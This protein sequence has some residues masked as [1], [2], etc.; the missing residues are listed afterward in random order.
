[1]VLGASTRCPAGHVLD[2]FLLS[3]VAQWWCPP[4]APGRGMSQPDRSRPHEGRLQWPGGHHPRAT[5]GRQ[6]A[7]E[8]PT[9]R[10]HWPEGKLWLS[11]VIDRGEKQ[12]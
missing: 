8:H 9:G 10:H 5:C 2:V 12:L 6:Q 1:M 7:L 3:T 11:G 4:Q